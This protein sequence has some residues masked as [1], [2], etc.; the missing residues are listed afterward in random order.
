MQEIAWT[1]KVK[2]YRMRILLTVGMVSTFL[3]SNVSAGTN[4]WENLSETLTDISGIF[5]GFVDLITAALPVILIVAAI[6]FVATFFDKIL[7]MFGRI[8]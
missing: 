1:D 6:G 5:P 2:Q 4:V 3:V 8:G 7:G